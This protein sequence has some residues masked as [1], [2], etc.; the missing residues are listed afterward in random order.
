MN[1]IGNVVPITMISRLI[2]F[3][4][5]NLDELWRSSCAAS[6]TGS[7]LR[8]R[9]P[10]ILTILLTASEVHELLGNADHMLAEDPQLQEH[11]RQ[12][13]DVVTSLRRRSSSS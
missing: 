7:S 11:L 13:L 8:P 5:N 4:D 3:S 2:G 10:R 9:L 6:S 1:A 12:N